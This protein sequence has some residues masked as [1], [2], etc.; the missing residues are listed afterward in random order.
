[1]K[2]WLRTFP[3][4]AEL[5][6]TR[7]DSRASKFAP[8]RQHHCMLD[9][10]HCLSR[11]MYRDGEG[12]PRDAQ[13]ARA[14]TRTTSRDCP[15][16]GLRLGC[17]CRPAWCHGRRPRSLADLDDSGAL[18]RWWESPPSHLL[19]AA[20]AARDVSDACDALR[21]RF[22]DIFVDPRPHASATRVMEAALT[23]V[24]MGEVMARRA[25]GEEQ[26]ARAFLSWRPTLAFVAQYACHV[27]VRLPLNAWPTDGR[28]HPPRRRPLVPL[29]VLG[30]PRRPRALRLLRLALGPDL[31]I[32]ANA[33]PVV[34][35]T[36]A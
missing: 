11:G 29:W 8:C 35:G 34:L 19:E 6:T 2:K 24:V 14:N 7:R 1:M 3:T 13:T 32:S 12:T 21:E 9:G 36:L 17:G 28:L 27:V 30:V 10:S 26:A 18:P 22:E 20:H 25:F 15:H 4:N 33:D 31:S 16:D 23:P 5:A